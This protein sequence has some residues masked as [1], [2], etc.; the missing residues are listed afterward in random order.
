[1]YGREKDLLQLNKDRNDH[2]LDKFVRTRADKAHSKITNQLK[3]KK[4]MSLREQLIRASKARDQSAE[5]RIQQQMRE[6]TGE[7]KE[8]GQ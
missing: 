1:M 3:D 5:Q 4:L 6:H 7:S 8:T 2:S